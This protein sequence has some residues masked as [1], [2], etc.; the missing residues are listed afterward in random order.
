MS[1]ESDTIYALSSGGL[2]AGVG[3]IRVSGTRVRGITAAL[4]GSLPEAR[5]AVLKP[6]R[7]SDGHVLDT[8]LV[9]FF[10]SPHSFTGED[11]VEFHLHGG[12]AVVTRFLSELGSFAGTRPAVAGEFTRRAFVNGRVD[13]T[14]AEALSDLVSVETEM[15]RRLAV[16]GARGDQR[17]LYERWSL[18]LLHARA[19][20]EAEF[21]FSDEQDVPG[22]VFESMLPDLRHLVEEIDVHLLTEKASEIIRDGFRVA[23]AGVPNSGKSSLLNALAKRDVAIVTEEAGTTRDIVEVSLDLEGYKVIVSDTAGIREALGLAERIGIEKSRAA[24]G[25]ADLVLL[26]VPPDGLVPDLDIGQAERILRIR[27]KS[28][29]LPGD[30]EDLAVSAFTGTGIPELIAR[31]MGAVRI[32]TASAISSVGLRDRHASLLGRARESTDRAILEWRQNPEIAAEYLRQA[33]HEIG[34]I[35]GRVDVEDLLD[36]IFSKFCIGK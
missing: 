36:V 6:L 17:V 14:E 33:S 26:V 13:L 5:R 35:T 2:P 34:R 28:D 3:V 18:V 23:L 9:L 7:S 27:S 32:S 1:D 21:D 30:T 11:V 25:Q 4:A 31:I 8:G 19:M 24:I 16:L 22:S 12:K 15:Q 10:S 29:L 20:L